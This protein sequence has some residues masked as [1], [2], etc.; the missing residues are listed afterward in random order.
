[1]EDWFFAQGGVSDF[2][3]MEYRRL[4]LDQILLKKNPEPGRNMPI[5]TEYIEVFKRETEPLVK[6]KLKNLF[7]KKDLYQSVALDANYLYSSLI[8][9]VKG[10][11]ESVYVI[12]EDRNISKNEIPEQ[13][14]TQLKEVA[15]DFLRKTP[16][17]EVF[18]DQAQNIGLEF[19]V[20]AIR[21]FCN[22]QECGKIT[23]HSIYKHPIVIASYE[24]IHGNIQ[25][26]LSFTFFCKECKKELVSYLVRRDGVMFTLSGRTPLAHCR[27][28]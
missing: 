4:A 15:F 19:T 17:N 7:E 12:G 6:I 14:E 2:P 1:M 23:F 9:V 20:D 27:D 25:Q 8:P 16:L 24:D 28:A 21:T 10:K 5:S 3:K 11:H 26:I 22:S 18:I 13:I